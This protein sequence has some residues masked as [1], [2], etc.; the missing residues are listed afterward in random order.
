MLNL[1]IGNLIYAVNGPTS[2]LL[3]VQGLTIDPQSESVIDHWAPEEVINVFRNDF[4]YICDKNGK[5]Q[6]SQLT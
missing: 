2:S 3:P 6:I 1:F 5:G 4:Y